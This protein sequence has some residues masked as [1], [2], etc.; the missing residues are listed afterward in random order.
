[1]KPGQAVT[2]QI[3]PATNPLT[4]AGHV[5]EANSKTARVRANGQVYEVP[6]EKLRKDTR[7]I[8]AR[9]PCEMCGKPV[10][11]LQRNRKYC[12]Q[13]C[14]GKHRESKQD[15]AVFN[16]LVQLKIERQGIT[17]T[18]PKIGEIAGTDRHSVGLSI[19]RLIAAGRIWY[20]GG[21]RHKQIGVVGGRW[22]F[23][24]R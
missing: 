15:E 7:G 5:V 17:P 1:M 4:L 8:T 24:R 13:K 6:A 23:E 16:A 18:F 11:D 14:F 3:G 2:W 22:V 19:R 20:E 10:R 9:P 21:E 12:S